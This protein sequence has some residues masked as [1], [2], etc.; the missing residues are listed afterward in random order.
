MDSYDGSNPTATKEEVCEKLL[1]QA[2][3]Q[4]T[5]AS[6]LSSLMLVHR[7]IHKLGSQGYNPVNIG[8]AKETSHFSRFKSKDQSPGN[9]FEKK[10]FLI[11][12]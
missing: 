6:A 8:N 3:K 2:G 12:L 1:L 9:L 11:L 5:W 4:K 10:I 7:V